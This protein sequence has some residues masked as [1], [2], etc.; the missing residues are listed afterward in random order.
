M[1]LALAAANLAVW[2]L[3]LALGA[4]VIEPSAQQMFGY[5]G[6]LGA[7]TLEGEEWRLFTS[8]FLHYGVMHIGMNLYGLILGGRVVER[9]FGRLGFAVIYLVSGLAASLATALRPGVVSAGA[10]GAIFG[11]LGALG[12]YYVLHRERMDA[13]AAR[14]ATGLLV[15]V[16]YNVVF[17]LAKPGVDMY[18][19]LGGL[20]AGFVCGLAIEVARP[21]PRRPRTVAV[22]AAG[23]V[24]VVV[25]A[26]LAPAPVDKA[27]QEAQRAI[28]AL[29]ETEQQIL[30]RWKELAV[31]GQQGIITPAQ[32]A[33]ALERDILGPWAMARGVFERSGASC[34]N[35]PPLLEYARARQAA[36]EVVLQGVRDDDSAAF[37]RG[38][39]QLQDA[40]QALERAMQP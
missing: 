9:L 17:G 37:D 1:T 8:M 13:R 4:P 39:Q 26:F 19:H 31:Q 32:F 5:G 12:A 16:G 20:A 7:V 18:A 28:D 6:N 38:I 40:E 23:L 2:I 14:E 27:T 33:D 36:F 30:A 11:V 24:A 35:C 3:T 22:G 10:S 21:G 34:P 25:A 15:F 29:L